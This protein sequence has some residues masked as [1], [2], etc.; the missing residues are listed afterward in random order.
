[1]ESS[2]CREG[3]WAEFTTKVTSMGLV[4]S[5]AHEKVNKYDK[6]FVYLSKL[7]NGGFFIFLFS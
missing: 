5:T 4:R 3:A 6:T 1:M 7:E 2:G